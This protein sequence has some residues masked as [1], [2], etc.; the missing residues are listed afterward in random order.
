MPRGAD[1]AI[2]HTDR[3]RADG[4]TAIFIDG[5]IHQHDHIA[6]KDEKAQRRLENEGWLVLR[7]TADRSTWAEVFVRNPT[8]FGAGKQ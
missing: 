2:E 5:P 7:F 3:I 8:V 6:A 1:E 4:D